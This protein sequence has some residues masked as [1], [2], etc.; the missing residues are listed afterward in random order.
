MGNIN[1]STFKCLVIWFRRQMEENTLIVK[2]ILYAPHRDTSH[3]PE[4]GS[5][6]SCMAQK[7]ANGM[8]RPSSLKSW[9]ESRTCWKQL[10]MVSQYGQKFKPE[11]ILAPFIFSPHSFLFRNICNGWNWKI[12][13]PSGY[14]FKVGRSPGIVL[15]P[16]AISHTIPSPSWHSLVTP[17]WTWHRNC[18]QLL[19][20]PW[21]VSTSELAFHLSH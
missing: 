17:W 20:M 21:V 11:V 18:A 14:F 10:E 6:E 12:F 7:F 5:Q 4:T 1:Y 9:V 13:S 19:D 3:L 16:V 8:W 15:S 2:C